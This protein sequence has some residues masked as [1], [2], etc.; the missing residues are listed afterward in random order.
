MIREIIESCNKETAEKERLRNREVELSS[1]EIPLEEEFLK[2]IRKELRAGEEEELPPDLILIQLYN[3]FRRGSS[4]SDEEKRQI[5][6]MI[7]KYTARMDDPRPY[8][9]AARI[10]GQPRDIDNRVGAL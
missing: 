3:T 8:W 10:S 5:V 6:M 9:S 7:K 2:C 1:L 4:F